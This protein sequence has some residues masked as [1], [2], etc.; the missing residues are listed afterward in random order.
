MLL[1]T[2]LRP[3]RY[4]EKMVKG[5]ICPRSYY[6]CSHIG[7]PAKK[8]VERDPETGKV[9]EVEYKGEHTHPAP[10]AAKTMKQRIKPRMMDP[11]V[12]EAPLCK[13]W[14]SLAAE[15]FI[16]SA[17]APMDHQIGSVWLCHDNGIH[18]LDMALAGHQM[19]V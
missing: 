3:A 9:N 15:A 13:L 12:R 7:C 1:N 18:R 2:A 16:E 19:H 5:S 4:G 8:I 14:R 17:V 11:M 10:S 6:K